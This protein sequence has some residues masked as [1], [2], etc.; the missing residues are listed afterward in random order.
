MYGYFR[1]TAKDALVADRDQGQIAMG[2]VV[3]GNQT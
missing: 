3:E 1:P 2:P